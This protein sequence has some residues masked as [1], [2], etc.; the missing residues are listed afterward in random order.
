MLGGVVMLLVTSCWVYCDG[1]PSYAGGVVMLLVASCWAPCDGLVSHP[2]GGVVMLLVSSCYRNQSYKS[3]NTGEPRGL[4]N[5]L[6]VNTNFTY[7]I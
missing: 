5:P 2:G 7:L 3:A 6:D 4:S 1:L